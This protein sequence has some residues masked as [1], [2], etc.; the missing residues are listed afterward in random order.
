M[1]YSLGSWGIVMLLKASVRLGD[2]TLIRVG[3]MAE[4]M[5]G[6]RVW[7]MAEAIRQYVT[8]EEWFIYKVEINT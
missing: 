6:A 2:D 5:D 7:L 8:R 4:V 3:Q 1:A